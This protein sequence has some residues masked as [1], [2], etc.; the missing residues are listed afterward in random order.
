[1]LE[2]IDQDVI[3]DQDL[4][5]IAHSE[6][7]L[8][9]TFCEQEKISSFAPSLKII[10]S[11]GRLQILEIPDELDFNHSVKR[12]QILLKLGQL[13]YQTWEAEVCPMVVILT[14]EAWMKSFQSETKP[15]P[16]RTPSDYP[17]AIDAIVIQSITFSKDSLSAAEHSPRACLG[18]LEIKQRQPYL[19]TEILVEPII[20]PATPESTDLLNHF[21]RGWFQQ[22]MSQNN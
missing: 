15:N 17:D 1:M 18:V 5:A 19:Q 11:E 22:S 2:H 20:T 21:Y 9:Q 12:R 16:Y 8:I 14:S 6:I 7:D 10:D 13:F 3:T 4:L